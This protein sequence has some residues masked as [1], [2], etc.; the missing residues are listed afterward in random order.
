MSQPVLSIVLPVFNEERAIGE[1]L[2]R[3]R[4][5]LVLK[6][7]NAE[8]LVASDGSTDATDRI[9][10]EEAAKDVRVRLISAP[11]NRGKG[12]AARLGALAASGDRILL[13]DCDLSAPIKEVDKLLFAI[14]RGADVAIGSRAVR[15]PD[16]DVRQSR[17]RWLS[18]R[19]F[20]FFVRALVVR[21][22]GDTQ[23]GFKL[24]TREASAR[25]F[26]RQRIEGFAFDVELL[27]LARKEG[28]KVAEVP[29]MWGEGPETKIR[30]VR[31]S[32]RMLRDLVRIRGL[33]RPG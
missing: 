30:L 21:G 13:T 6:N 26:S 10:S 23:C 31:D 19:I 11:K 22:F 12:A 4:A 33:H 1:A 16:A 8:I 3:I 25:L 5:F 28:L 27:Y 17:K 15:S 2:R 14:D 24:F 7:W 20:N 9:V 32:T 18:G 29:V